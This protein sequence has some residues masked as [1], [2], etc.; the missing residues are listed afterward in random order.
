MSKSVSKKTKNNNTLGF[1][2]REKVL[3]IKE[4]PVPE[5]NLHPDPPNIILPKHEFSI[6]IVGILF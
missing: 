4:I 5:D 1:K 3:K 6:G 2:N